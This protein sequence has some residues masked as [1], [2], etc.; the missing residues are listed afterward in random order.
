MSSGPQEHAPARPAPPAPRTPEPGRATVRAGAATDARLTG[1]LPAPTRVRPAPGVR[2]RLTA[3]TVIRTGADPAAGT[4]ADYLATLLRPATGHPLPVTR[5]DD[6]TL[7]PVD[8]I[9]LLLDPTTETSETGTAGT[10]SAGSTHEGGYR[11]D[12]T[13]D[14]IVIR[15]RDRAGLFHGV[16]TLRQLLP[17]AIESSTVQPGPWEVPGGEIVDT[18]RFAYRGAMLDVS[19][20]FFEVPDVLRLVDQL[21]RYK[22]NHLHLHLTDDQG[23]RIAIDSWPKLAEVGG[24]TEVDGGVGGYYTQADYRT[25]VEYAATR[26]ITVVPEIDLPGHTNAALHAY[27]ELAPDGV[28]PA[29]YTGTE[30]GFSYLAVDNERTYDFVTDVLGELAALTPGAYLHVGGDEAF[31]LSPADYATVMN[32]V[33]RIVADTGRT[34]V[35]WHQLAP[36]EHVP[37][38]VLQYW[39]TTTADEKVAAAVAQGARVIMSPGNRTYLDMKY[40]ESTTLGQDW[41]GL[42]EVRTAYDWDP[43]TYLDGVPEEAVLGV[44]A[45]LWT[46]T[47]RTVPEI[48]YMTFPR[49]VAVA[50]LGWSTAPARDWES[51]R[52]RLAAHSP[53]WDTASIAY[54]PS[55]E[56]PWP[57]TTGTGPAVPSPRREIGPVEPTAD[58]GAQPPES[59]ISAPAGTTSLSRSDNQPSGR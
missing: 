26:H 56:V 29:A 50:E 54:H 36:A 53:R 45:P 5:A 28:A 7:P 42:I 55:P 37:G 24:A 33:Q 27:P 41:A 15:A 39:G 18:P 47:I 21:A 14:G 51:F 2:Y 19:R 4:V 34:V 57:T 6:G 12:V 46:E 22:L 8:A 49:L 13:G 3:E 40:T 38:R 30:V 44:E 31:K 58:G 43:G 25:I 32:R 35:G 10:G 52:L 17:A 20:H 9:T 11:L 48:E 1:V 59:S 16:Q 23:W